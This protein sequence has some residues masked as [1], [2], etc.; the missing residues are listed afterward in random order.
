M[1]NLVKL[2]AIFLLVVIVVL[3]F[4]YNIPQLDFIFILRVTVIP[5]GADC[6]SLI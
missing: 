4:V 2:L 6:L 5:E 1:R 3:L